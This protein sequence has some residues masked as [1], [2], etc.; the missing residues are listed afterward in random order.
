[1]CKTPPLLVCS[2]IYWNGPAAVCLSAN[3]YAVVKR[4]VQPPRLFGTNVA[5]RVPGSSADS[6]TSVPS[7]RSTVLSAGKQ[8]M[9]LCPAAKVEG[10]PEKDSSATNFALSLYIGGP[11][12]MVL[13]CCGQ[14][15]RCSQPESSR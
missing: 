12:V 2:A 5:I 13:P 15:L 1:M 7:A 11:S 9:K 4:F 14:K 10:Q 3:A 8:P 6:G